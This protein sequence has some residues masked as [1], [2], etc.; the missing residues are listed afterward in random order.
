MT[1]VRTSEIREKQRQKMLENAKHISPEEKAERARKQKETVEK[2]GVR[3]G[4]PP[5]TTETPREQRICPVCST[6]FEVMVTETKR[7]CRIACANRAP[8]KVQK[9]KDM[10]KSY[11]KTEAYR[12]TK[13]NPNLPA[14]KRYARRVRILS[15]ENYTKHFGL[16][17][18]NNHPRTICGVDGGWQLDHIKSI[19]KCFNEG[20]SPEEAA[21]VSNLQLVPWK[22]NLAKRTFEPIGDREWL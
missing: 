21:D 22:E 3:V 5:G 10:D 12:A 9:M 16:L 6:S 2:N 8:E 7:F 19:K 20:L 17:N 15:D 18:P 11:M 14:Y 1:Y 4:R 13:R